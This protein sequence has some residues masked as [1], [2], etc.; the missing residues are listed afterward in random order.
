MVTQ[1][2]WAARLTLN[3]ASQ[4]RGYRHERGLSAQQLADRC[5]DLGMDISRATLADIENGRRVAISVAELLILAR[6]LDVPPILLIAPAG[7]QQTVE[8]FPDRFMDVWDAVL[9]LTGQAELVDAGAGKPL[10]VTRADEDA[11]VE[12][13]RMHRFLVDRAPRD[14]SALQQALASADLAETEEAADAARRVAKMIQANVETN[15]EDLRSVRARMR[16]RGLAP[17]DLSAAW[18]VALG[19]TG[20]DAALHT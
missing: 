18:L 10:T 4:V 11:T 15:I 6:A 5:A 8:I 16:K 14:E 12:L 9:W 20:H 17:P 2:T 13:F 3:V 7:R 1:P 19:E